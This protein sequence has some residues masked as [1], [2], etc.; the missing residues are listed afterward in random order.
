MGERGSV[1]GRRLVALVGSAGL[2]LSACGGDA[3]TGGG[4]GA[5]GEGPIRIGLTAAVTGP[6][7]SL[8]EAQVRGVEMAV[9][10][11][12]E[13]GMLNGRPVELVVRD[14]QCSP[15]RG[16]TN[17]RDLITREGVA[18]IVGSTCSGSTIP[19]APILS[20]E[21]VPLM[22]AS[23]A[24]DVVSVVE[25]EENYVFRA[26]LFDAAQTAAAVAGAVDQGFTSIA[27]ATDTSAFGQGGRRD[28]LAALEEQGITPVADVTYSAGDTDLTSQMQEIAQAGADVVINWGY[29]PEAVQLLRAGERIG[30]EG[31][32]IYSWAQTE[33]D[34]LSLAAGSAEGVL[35]TGSFSFDETDEPAAAELEAAYTERYG[36][37]VGFPNG[38]AAWYDVTGMLFAAMEGAGS[39]DGPAI[40][41]AL[42][43]LQNYEGIINT[44]EDPFSVDDRDAVGVEDIGLFVLQDGKFVRPGG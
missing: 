2:L 1:V 4:G 15:E 6:V 23:G 35:F 11:L 17:A 12:L 25:G 32:F 43:D 5:A 19:I 36:E 18:A 39:T 9:Q 38:F 27:I 31:E 21:E 41:Q 37:E 24:T 14:D 30:Y 3:E 42:F 34:F 44:Y 26:S 13:G 33:P 28:L 16:V 40:Q 22:T 8:G 20:D 7:A 29:S 10:E